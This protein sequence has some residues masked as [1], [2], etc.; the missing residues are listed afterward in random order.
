MKRV[1]IGFLGTTLDVG[2]HGTRWAR[3]RPTIALCTQKDLPID[4]LELIHDDR[5]LPLARRIVDDI[6]EV[7]PNTQVCARRKTCRSIDWS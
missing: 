3:W 6:R 5:A 4:R 2:K 7:A 1:A